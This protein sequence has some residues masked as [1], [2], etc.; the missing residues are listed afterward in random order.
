MLEK[1]TRIE[2]V[3]EVPSMSVDRAL[4]INAAL[5]N[6]WMIRERIKPGIVPD[7]TWFNPREAEAAIGMIRDT[8]VG[9]RLNGDGSVT[10]TC[11]VDPSRI[12]A[13]YAWALAESVEEVADV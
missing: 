5:V 9:R 6:A 13:L 12:R 8:G 10:L 7:V 1:L 3:S 2:T 11:C 4:A